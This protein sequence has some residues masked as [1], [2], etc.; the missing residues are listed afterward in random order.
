MANTAHSII[1]PAT[2]IK[3]TPYVRTVLPASTY[4]PA[5]AVYLTA[6]TTAT[7][8][9]T[10]TGICKLIKP[11]FLEFMPRIMNH[12][13]KDCDDA[14]E[15]TEPVNMII[16]G[17]NGPLKMVIK[18]VDLG[19]TIYPGHNFMPGS[20]AGSVSLNAGAGTSDTIDTLIFLAVTGINTDVY[21]TAWVY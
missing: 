16:G 9:D 19:D 10:D 4:N 17:V 13:R 6:E 2:V 5:D 7:H 12:T 8:L 18:V 11:H 21:A 20:T 3:G 14:Y 1:S 15:A